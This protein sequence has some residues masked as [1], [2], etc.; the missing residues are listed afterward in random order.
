MEKAGGSARYTSVDLL[1]AEG[2]ERAIA[3]VRKQ[4]GRIDVLV[5]AAGLEISH[6]LPDKEPR[7]FDLVF[8]VKSSGWFHLLRAVGDMPLGATVSFSSI[9]GRFGNAG[10]TDYSAANDLLCKSVSNFRSTRP[11]TLGIAIDW[12]AWGGNGMAARGVDGR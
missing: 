11:D 12:T 4:H 7:E 8:D 9:A 10:Q 6:V 3:E 5:H 1:D 2:V